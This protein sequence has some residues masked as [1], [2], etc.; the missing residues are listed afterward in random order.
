MFEKIKQQEE[1][2]KLKL[3]IAEIRTKIN[4]LIKLSKEKKETKIEPKEKVK[5]GVSQ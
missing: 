3:E 5:Q 1:I 4:Y 2:N